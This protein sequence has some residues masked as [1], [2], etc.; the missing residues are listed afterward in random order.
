MKSITFILAL[1]LVSLAAFPCS[2]SKSCADEKKQGVAIT[3]TG[4]HN[5]SGNEKDFCSPF[6]ICSCCSVNV[7]VNNIQGVTFAIS[8]AN[9]K[10]NTLYSETPPLQNAE[11][12]WQPPRI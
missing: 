5:H 9:G 12:I 4:D 10:L 8:P 7:Q 1:Y 3:V 2:D 6:C 11:S